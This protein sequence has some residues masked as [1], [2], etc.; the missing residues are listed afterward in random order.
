MVEVKVMFEVILDGHG[1]CY[2]PIGF[3]GYAIL[4]SFFILLRY[5]EVLRSIMSFYS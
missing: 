3:A 4:I 5:F 1:V 2:A